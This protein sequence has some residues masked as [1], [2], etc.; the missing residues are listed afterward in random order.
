MEMKLKKANV[1]N[2]LLKAIKNHYS[3]KKENGQ[4]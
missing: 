2:K 1:G 3:L 4:C